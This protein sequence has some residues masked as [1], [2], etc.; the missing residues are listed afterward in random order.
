MQAQSFFHGTSNKLQK[1]VPTY[2]FVAI[3]SDRFFFQK[4]LKQQNLF[5]INCPDINQIVPN[6]VDGVTMVVVTFAMTCRCLFT[7]F[8][9][10]T[11]QKISSQPSVSKGA[12]HGDGTRELQD[13]RRRG[14]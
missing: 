4:I 12:S 7:N 13:A 2:F 8:W 9:Q 6:V 3:C 10:P 14:G 5:I 1:H 11:S